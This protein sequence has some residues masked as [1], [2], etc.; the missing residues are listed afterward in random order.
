LKYFQAVLNKVFVQDRSIGNYYRG[1]ALGGGEGTVY[2]AIIKDTDGVEHAI[3]VAPKNKTTGKTL[4]KQMSKYVYKPLH[5]NDMLSKGTSFYED[6]QSKT[7]GNILKA[8]KNGELNSLF[9]NVNKNAKITY[10]DNAYYLEGN[11]APFPS[12]AQLLYSL[13]DNNRYNNMIQ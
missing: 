7:I 6:G 3:N 8:N 11:A 4:N 1:E 5:F 9:E 2:E 10:K 13:K 12:V